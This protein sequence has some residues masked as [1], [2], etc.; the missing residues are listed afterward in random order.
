MLMVREEEWETKRKSDLM[1]VRYHSFGGDRT[2][3][4][5]FAI[6]LGLFDGDGEIVLF[7]LPFSL[8]LLMFYDFAPRYRR[9]ELAS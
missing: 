8:G 9:L 7:F 5:Y 4:G 3:V 2:A 1:Y 6:P